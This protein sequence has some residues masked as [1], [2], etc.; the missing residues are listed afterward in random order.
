MAPFDEPKLLC[1]LQLSLIQALQAGEESQTPCSG[2]YTLSWLGQYCQCDTSG[3]TATE[4]T[5]VQPMCFSRMQRMSAKAFEVRART[6]RLVMRERLAGDDY[7]FVLIVSVLERL[8]LGC[9]LQVIPPLPL[10]LPEDDSRSRLRNHGCTLLI[11]P[12]SYRI[13]ASPDVSQIHCSSS[14]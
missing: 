3:Q 1:H 6:A 8:L 11:D 2:I 4:R 13:C 5:S 12:L 7:P 10:I 14:Q 9:F